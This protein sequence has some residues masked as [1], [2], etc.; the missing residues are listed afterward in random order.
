MKALDLKSNG[1]SLRRF[2]SCSQRELL[3]SGRPCLIKGP[4]FTTLALAV[5]PQGPLTFRRGPRESPVRRAALPPPLVVTRNL[6]IY[7]HPTYSACSLQPIT[8]SWLPS[9]WGIFLLGAC[10]LMAVGGEEA[11]AAS[12]NTSNPG[13]APHT[14]C[15]S[16]RNCAEP[17]EKAGTCRN[18]L[19]WLG[20]EPRPRQ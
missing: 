8:G 20:I 6:A 19:P 3:L 2:K 5:I 14:G 15:E 16:S 9:T 7:V 4:G 12:Q 10:S 17:Q 1:V 13:S 11:A 18:P